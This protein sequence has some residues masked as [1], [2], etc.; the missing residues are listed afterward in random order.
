MPT[1]SFLP[2]QNNFADLREVANDVLKATKETNLKRLAGVVGTLLYRCDLLE[3]EVERL[4]RAAPAK[5]KPSRRK[6]PRAKPRAR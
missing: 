1:P 4:G 3:R 5:P 6:A 2:S